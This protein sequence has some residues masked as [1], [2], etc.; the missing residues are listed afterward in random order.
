MPTV[1]THAVLPLV[2]VVALSSPPVS[3][4]LVVAAMVAGMLPD[5]DVV[6]RAFGIPHTADLGHRGAT[7]SI[8]FAA[9]AGFIGLTLHRWFDVPR[10]R[11]ALV[12]FLSTLS[13]PLTDMLTDGGKGMMLFW[14]VEHDRFA[15][16]ARPV[17]VS[18]VG[19]QDLFSGRIWSVLASEAV[20]LIAPA[21]VLGLL[22]HAARRSFARRP[23]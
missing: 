20:F 22:F 15:F 9:L 23:D 4:R 12:L 7:H 5:A 10:R 14:P 11:A 18:H 19:L 2:G 17:T 6:G 8:L 13:H 3:R 21:I 1:L 16:L